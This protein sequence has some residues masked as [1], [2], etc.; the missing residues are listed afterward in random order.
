MSFHQSQF[1]RVVMACDSSDSF[2]ELLNHYDREIS[3]GLCPQ[4]FESL[5]WQHSFCL[6]VRPVKGSWLAEAPWDETCVCAFGRQLSH[7]S[8][9]HLEHV[10][11]SIMHR[12]YIFFGFAKCCVCISWAMQHFDWHEGAEITN[13]SVLFRVQFQKAL[14]T[15][16]R[17]IHIFLQVLIRLCNEDLVKYARHKPDFLDKKDHTRQA[18][19]SVRELHIKDRRSIL[20]LS[21]ME[22]IS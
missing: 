18:L 5:S 11:D 6:S 15:H 22:V 16:D 14:H 19:W 3:H 9:W 2:E 1:G 13:C 4:G 17:V 20:G 8:E 12:M 10:P 21:Q 7:A